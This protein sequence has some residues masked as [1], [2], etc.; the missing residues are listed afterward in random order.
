[1]SSSAS[2][3]RR[4]ISFLKSVVKS[5]AETRCITQNKSQAGEFF[6]QSSIQAIIALILLI[7]TSEHV[8]HPKR[9]KRLIGALILFLVSIIFQIVGTNKITQHS[10]E[11]YEPFLYA[12]NIPGKIVLVILIGVL[13]I[14]IGASVNNNSGHTVL[15][16]KSLGAVLLLNE[17]LIVHAAL[18]QRIDMGD[19]DIA[20]KFLVSSIFGFAATMLY[21][22]Y[23]FHNAT[24]DAASRFLLVIFVFVTTAVTCDLAQQVA[25]EFPP[26][27][28]NIFKSYGSFIGWNVLLIM[29]YLFTR[30]HLPFNLRNEPQQSSQ[31][32]ISM[33]EPV[34]G[35][36]AEP[37]SNTYGVNIVEVNAGENIP[38]AVAVPVAG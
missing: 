2:R 38:T 21:M 22:R 34:V 25:A 17:L 35:S 30:I 12:Q 19:K 18:F 27:S 33:Q 4:R 7:H 5:F 20:N 8:Q 24:T 13:V 11:F 16:D 26:N 31:P 28:N 15:T 6:V 10:N 1:M 29:P 37:V 32:S 14:L 9:R 3:K 23:K 36:S